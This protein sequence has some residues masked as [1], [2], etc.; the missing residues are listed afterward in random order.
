MINFWNLRGLGKSAF[1]RKIVKSYF[2]I[3]FRTGHIHKIKRGPLAGKNWY[4]HKAH[5]FWMPL[6]L[7][8][9][10]TADWLKSCLRPGMTFL[11]IGANAGYFTLLGS[12]IVGEEVGGVTIAFEPVPVNVEVIKN[13]LKANNIENVMVEELAISNCSG[14]VIFAIEDTNAN[15]HMKDINI[16]HANSNPNDEIRVRSITLDEYVIKQ[17]I[18]PD[19]IKIDVEGAEMKVLD[20]GENTF[21][22]VRPISI[23]STHSDIL[24]VNCREFFQIRNYDV[25][26]LEGFEHELICIPK[27]LKT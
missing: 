6:G 8:E 21:Q 12:S 9:K 16:T 22:N 4:C 2:Q 26:T 17:K 10:E 27:R 5:Q 1:L 24:N 15:S 20:G 19:L 14:E 3:Y 25:T 13:H 23:V 18:K 7:Y 11:D